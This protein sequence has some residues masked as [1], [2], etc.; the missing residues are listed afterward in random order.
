M[1]R[2]KLFLTVLLISLA[3]GLQAQTFNAASYNIRNDNSGDVAAGN[4]WKIRF[5]YIAKQILFNEFDIFGT[6]EGLHHQLQDLKDSLPGY[7]YI[8][9][10]RDDGQQ[11]GE[12]SAIFYNKAK[13][14]LLKKGDFWLSPIT[15]KPNK[16]WDAALPRICSW[17]EFQIIG[18]KTRFYFFNIHFDHVGVEARK[19]SSKLILAKIQEFA[20]Q[21]NII[22]TGDFNVDQNNESYHLLNNSGRLK[23]SYILAKIKYAPNGTFNGFNVNT[24]T[25]SRIDHLFVSKAFTVKKYGILTDTYPGLPAKKNEAADSSNF[26]KEVSLEKNQARLPSDHYPVMIQVSL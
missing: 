26:P 23:D 1:R 6:Q 15:D 20:P 16:G 14:K 25:D 17:G 19:E 9:V 8:G 4:G 3:I 12:Y 10:G 2:I 22:L 11:K 24:K 18:S 13:F 5:P 7:D 21:G